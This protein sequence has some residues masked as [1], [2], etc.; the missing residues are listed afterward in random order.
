MVG[1]IGW[2]EEKEPKKGSRAAEPLLETTH[3]RYD[4]I[5]WKTSSFRPCFYCVRLQLKK[6]SAITWL[7]EGQEGWWT[8]SSFKTPSSSI[9]KSTITSIKNYAAVA[10]IYVGPCLWW[11]LR[12]Y[13]KLQLTWL[14]ISYIIIVS[15]AEYR[16]PVYIRLTNL[17]QSQRV[18]TQTTYWHITLTNRWSSS[19]TFANY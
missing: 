9:I 10:E 19:L 16:F 12:H 11:H 15:G 6:R 18:S 17:W 4:Q 2:F 5:T 7:G 14:A 8:S 13:R 1:V 3:P